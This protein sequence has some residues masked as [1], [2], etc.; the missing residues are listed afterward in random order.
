MEDTVVA[1]S[2]S[3]WNYLICANIT[4]DN[5]ILYMPAGWEEWLF[6][7]ACLNLVLKL[8]HQLKFSWGYGRGVV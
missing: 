2:I 7:A 6:L 8:L 1:T 3:F 4:A 5:K